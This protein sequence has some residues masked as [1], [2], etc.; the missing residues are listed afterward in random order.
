M[1]I[2]ARPGVGEDVL[3][4]RSIVFRMCLL[5]LAPSILRD[6]G[7]E[8]FLPRHGDELAPRL[9]QEISPVGLQPVA[10]PPGALVL[11]SVPRDLGRVGNSIDNELRIFHRSARSPW[12]AA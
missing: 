1:T 2:E 6:I 5:R 4:Q 12:L 10:V 7:D 3:A 11:G 9:G 8:R